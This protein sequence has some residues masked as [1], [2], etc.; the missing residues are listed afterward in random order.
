[1]AV[2][3]AALVVVAVG[4]AAFV[5]GDR[6]TGELPP[7]AQPFEQVDVRSDVAGVSADAGIVP[8]TWG[9][10][11]KLVATGFEPGQSYLVTVRTQDGRQRSAGGFVGT[12]EREMRCNL[13]ADVLRSDATGFTVVDSDGNAVLSAE[14][15]DV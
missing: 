5:A 6:R 14:L 10:E 9:V 8:H 1:M 15:P 4:A 7:A 2:A 12:G 11:I 13:N 3:A